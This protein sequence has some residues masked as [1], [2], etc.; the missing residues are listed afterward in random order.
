MMK[1]FCAAVL[2][3]LTVQAQA[4]IPACEADPRL[5][6]A[7]ITEQIILVGET[8][9]TEQAPAFVA[10]LVCGLLAQH[11]PV[12]LALERDEAEQ[13]AT[14]RFLASPGAAAD[15]GAL[16]GQAEWN[17]AMQDGRSSQAM[18]RLLDHLRKWRQAG[19]RVELLMMRKP[20]RFDVPDTAAS[21]PKMD[22]KALQAKLDLDMADSVSAA[23]HRH[24]GHVAV[25]FAGTFHTA[26]GSK[27][28][29]D[30]IGA[31]SMGDVLAARTP[32]HV[33][34][35]GSAGGESWACLQASGCGPTAQ[36]A[37]N[38]DLPDARVDTHIDLGPITA[39]SPAVRVDCRVSG[40]RASRPAPA[41][42][43]KGG[44]PA[45]DSRCP[46]RAPAGR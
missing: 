27:V 16:L 8:H 1:T 46:D 37:G 28:H 45:A 9:G 13:V 41:S 30:I 32:V 29:Q 38:F 12:I 23:L 4:A 10:R 18:L 44:R 11:R 14:E 22:P 24:P 5:K 20:Q 3:L 19:Q 36:R 31:P 42:A 25:V 15:V 39:S 40:L 35:L 7:R 33:I 17:M 6:L 26:V 43:A 2:G 21:A 34:G